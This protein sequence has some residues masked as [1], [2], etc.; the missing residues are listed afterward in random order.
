MRGS[1]LAIALGAQEGGPEAGKDSVPPHTCYQQRHTEGLETAQN[2]GMSQDQA[3]HVC[4]M[5]QAVR[6]QL[7]ASSE[8]DSHVRNDPPPAALVPKPGQAYN[9]GS[10]PSEPSEQ[11]E[12][13]GVAALRVR[14]VELGS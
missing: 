14:F 7:A 4:R 11:L 6:A 1:Q 8:L 5:F 13:I 12:G 10:R 3:L 2:T 9:S